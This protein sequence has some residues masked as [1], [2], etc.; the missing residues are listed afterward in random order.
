ML[1]QIIL[2][3]DMHEIG[4]LT[5]SKP[6]ACCRAACPVMLEAAALKERAGQYQNAP[7]KMC[8]L[9]PDTE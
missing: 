5:E 9:T 2:L 4:Y 3:P 8:C 1:D 6:V 7:F